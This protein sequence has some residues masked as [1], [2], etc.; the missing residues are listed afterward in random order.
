MTSARKVIDHKDEWIARFAV[1]VDARCRTRRAAWPARAWLDARL[2]VGRR[3]RE[4][5]LIG[6]AAVERVVRA[7]LVV[8]VDNQ[9]DLPLELRLVLRYRDHPQKF[10]DRPMKTFDDGDT[11]VFANG[12]E[13]RQDVR[14]LAPLLEVFAFEL[15]ALI[16]DQVLW[17]GSF[18][19]KDVVEGRGHVLR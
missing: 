9:F 11:A 19:A 18:L 17:F 6:R 2:L 10:F 15:A 16:D 8:P 13:S 4:E 12:T 5:D 3:T 14:C 7:V 1:N